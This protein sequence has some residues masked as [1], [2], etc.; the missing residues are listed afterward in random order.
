MD[1]VIDFFDVIVVFIV[2]VVDVVVDVIVVVVVVVVVV[3]DVERLDD[4]KLP[5]F[6]IFAEKD[7]ASFRELLKKGIKLP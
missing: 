1:E 4:P 7:L 6:T 5:Y 3:V 2:V